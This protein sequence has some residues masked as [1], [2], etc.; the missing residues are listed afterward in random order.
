MGGVCGRR[1][2][3]LH[4]RAR[5]LACVTRTLEL[6]GSVLFAY[7]TNRQASRRRA[8]LPADV[9]VDTYHAAF[10]LDDPKP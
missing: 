2:L 8:K 9:A 4:G 1:D 6:G 5:A 7:P 10:G 3:R